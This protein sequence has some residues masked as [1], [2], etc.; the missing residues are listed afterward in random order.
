M[1]PVKWDLK[2]LLGKTLDERYLVEELLG[3]GGMG[4]V[5]RATH[6]KTGSN[7]VAVKILHL[8]W[9]DSEEVTLR[10]RREARV[11]MDLSDE[12]IVHIHDYSVTPDG[13]P[14]IAMEYLEGEDLAGLIQ[15]EAPLDLERTA[16]L[17]RQMGSALA[18]AHR[19]GVVHRDLKPQNVFIKHK[20]IGEDVVKVVDFGIAKVMDSVSVVTRTGAVMGTP[21]FMAPEQASEDHRSLDSRADI[22]SLGCIIY[23]MLSGKMAFAGDTYAKVLMSIMSSEPRPLRS[24]NPSIPPAVEAVVHR[25]LAKDREE[26]FQTAAELVRT[27][28]K[29]AAMPGTPTRVTGPLPRT[30]APAS[31]DLSTTGPTRIDPPGGPAALNI[32]VLTTTPASG[33][34]CASGEGGTDAPPLAPTGV[35]KQPGTKDVGLLPT[36]PACMVSGTGTGEKGVL[37]TTPGTANMDGA[38]NQSAGPGEEASLPTMPSGHLPPEGVASQASSISATTAQPRHRGVLALVIVLGLL[39][40]VGIPMAVW[41]LGDRGGPVGLG[42]SPAPGGTL[43]KGGTPDIRHA[44]PAQDSAVPD[45]ETADMPRPDQRPPRRR[46]AR[47]VLNVVTREDGKPV[48]A[49]IFLDG[50]PLG[51][52]P[53]QFRVRAGPHM[54]RAVREGHPPKHRS[55]TLKPGQRKSV[56]LDL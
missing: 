48:S 30:R 26:R 12:N 29:A 53:G 49:R 52:S 3:T 22:F 8:D 37:P 28:W 39:V 47:A 44:P 6:V 56:L 23:Q 19:Q 1:S 20:P 25:A 21:N 24:L 15:R 38:G 35:M 31:S 42:A 5:F 14:Y 11:A 17:V 54:L 18:A 13:I 7:R 46:A 4:S 36:T 16:E 51:K 40:L 45:L 41:Q 55:I 2:D 43:H 33:H 34:I 50:K 10:F 27:F 9:Q 32:G